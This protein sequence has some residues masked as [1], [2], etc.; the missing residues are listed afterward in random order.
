MSDDIQF[1][2]EE[3]N[4]IINWNKFWDFI[5]MC[6]EENITQDINDRTCL[7]N[8]YEVA[9][10]A[11]ESFFNYSLKQLKQGF[12]VIFTDDI[13]NIKIQYNDYN[14]FVSWISDTNFSKNNDFIKKRIIE[15]YL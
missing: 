5:E 9:Y 12:K 11:L 10:H 7:N 2:I 3:N 8:D 1:S 6:V 14:D 4:V 13:N 15:K